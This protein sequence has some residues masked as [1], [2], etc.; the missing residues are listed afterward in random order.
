MNRQDQLDGYLLDHEVTRFL[1]HEAEILDGRRFDE[2]L[3][4]LADDMR[5]SMPVRVT[6]GKG[7]GSDFVPNSTWFGDSRRS[8]EMRV[9]QLQA[10][11]PIAEDPPSRTRHFVSNIRVEPTDRQDEVRARSNL[12]LYRNRGDSVEYDIFSAERVDTLR[13][14]NGSWKIVRREVLLDQA[15]MGAQDIPGFL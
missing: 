12:L 10:E 9:R 6:R 14:V 5:Y 8:L 2:W 1:L 7:A 11:H 3:D 4:L 13:R 15:V